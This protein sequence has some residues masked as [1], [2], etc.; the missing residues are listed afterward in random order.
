MAKVKQCIYA[1]DEKDAYCK[2]CN[3]ITIKVSG[4]DVSATGCPG[5]EIETV[6]PAKEDSTEDNKTVQEEK[7]SSNA[8]ETHGFASN[9]DD[10]NSDD[11]TIDSEEKSV[12]IDDK[13]DKKETDFSSE[14]SQTTELCFSSGASVEVNGMWYKF[15]CEERR[16]L[17]EGA[18][19]VEEREKL[20]ATVNNEVDKQLEDVIKMAEKK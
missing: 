5:Y 18:D 10:N 19:V 15:V 8:S 7:D 17:K 9:S 12:E 3:G 6:E 1:G 13:A 4:K 14:F 2:E 20:W 16:V 11:K